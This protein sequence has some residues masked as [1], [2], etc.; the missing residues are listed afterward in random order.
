MSITTNRTFG[1]LGGGKARPFS[2]ACLILSPTQITAPRLATTA[3][4]AGKL[5]TTKRLKMRRLAL[6]DRDEPRGKPYRHEQPGQA[7]DPGKGDQDGG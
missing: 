7:V 5:T 6:D 1:E 3:T 4:A 2:R